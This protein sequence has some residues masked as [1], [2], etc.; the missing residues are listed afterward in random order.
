MRLILCTLALFGAAVSGT[1]A[2]QSTVSH[3][4]IL[5]ETAPATLSGFGFF[6]GTV[7]RPSAELIPYT[8]RTALFSDYAVKQRFIVLP[9]N[10]A[11]IVEAGEG[12]LAFPVGTAIIKSFG[13]PDAKGHFKPIETRVLLHKAAGWAALPY[14]WQADGKDA[15]LRVGGSR[16]P[17]SFRT[18]ANVSKD[19]QYAVPNKNQ[20]KQCHAESGRIVPIGPRLANMDFAREA[21]KN[22]LLLG[23]QLPA[24]KQKTWPKWDDP[25]SGPLASRASAYLRIN[26]GHCHNPAGSA[27]NSGLY[28]DGQDYGPANAGILKRPVAAGRGAG[29]FDFVIKPG[30]PAQSILI[31]R[32][33]S[34]DSGVA[35]P[36]LGRA[37]VHAEGVRLLEEWIVEMKAVYDRAD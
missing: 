28:Y 11:V 21:D 4:A 10:T 33:K 9:K 3:T 26:C 16:V 37:T 17:V 6:N 12:R 15:D 23:A 24:G 13:Y 18:P 29:N 30:D 31:H 27:S 8:L 19:I 14:V 35:M 25:K 36:E 32:M 34:L 22:R 7:D 2:Q 5:S 1:A 20:C